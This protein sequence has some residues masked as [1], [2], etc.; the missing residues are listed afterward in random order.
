M[1]FRS[2]HQHRTAWE[3]LGRRDSPSPEPSGGPCPPKLLQASLLLLS[4]VF[5]TNKIPELTQFYW[6]FFLF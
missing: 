3:A 2:P 1:L 6:V 4:A 5:K